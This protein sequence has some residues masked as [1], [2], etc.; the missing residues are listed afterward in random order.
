MYTVYLPHLRI[1]YT[2]WMTG[3]RQPDGRRV[4]VTARIS[5][6]VMARLDEARG[7]QSRSGCLEQALK[8][9]LGAAKK[10]SVRRPAAAQEQ[11]EPE[12]VKPCTHS[13]GI[14]NGN[15]CPRCDRLV[16]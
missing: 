15:Y 5:E 4:V 12:V 3:K 10:V 2:G 11:A 13:P 7:E 1:R 6:E 14:R 16:T 8:V 9:Y